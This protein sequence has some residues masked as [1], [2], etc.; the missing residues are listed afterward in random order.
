MSGTSPG[1]APVF[2][3]EI[4]LD[5]LATVAGTAAAVIATLPRYPAAVRDLSILI[6]DRLPAASV[7]GTIRSNAPATLVAIREFD[8]YQGKGMATG[9]VSLSLRLKFQHPSRTLTDGEVQ[10][11]IDSIVAAL[12]R[13]HHATLRGK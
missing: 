6:S 5:A 11:A 3:G 4:D 2:A 1:D 7:R 13:E 9:Q 8:R 10:Q 12:E